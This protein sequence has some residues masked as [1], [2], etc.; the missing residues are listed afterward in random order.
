ML[1]Q[2]VYIIIARYDAE[3]LTLGC[4]TLH[5]KLWLIYCNLSPD[6]S[7]QTHVGRNSPIGEVPV[8]RGHEVPEEE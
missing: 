7:L 4:G 3:P 2:N 8:R 5:E 6:V 1:M